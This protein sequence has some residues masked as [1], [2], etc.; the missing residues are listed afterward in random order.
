MWF[1]K[2][3][4]LSELTRRVLDPQRQVKGF[5]NGDDAMHFS[6]VLAHQSALGVK[7]DIF[8]IGTYFG[9]STMVLAY[10]LVDG[11]SLRVCDA[12][13]LDTVD[14]YAD[15][16]TISDL[17]G[18]IRVS[19][20]DFDEAHLVVHN[21]LS[22]DLVLPSEARFRFA[23]IDGGHSR[24]EALGDLRLTA[25]HMIAGGVIAVDDYDHPK[26]PGVKEAVADFLNET[27]DFTVLADMNRWSALGRK[28]YLIRRQ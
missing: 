28:L 6:M 16:P 12:F 20:P 9:K 22:K 11:E 2:E 18:A 26:W 21:C 1:R 24:E 3:A 17:L 14:R 10:H 5:A 7:G 15:K 27:S 8:E 23:H 4:N 25:P 19:V 13:E